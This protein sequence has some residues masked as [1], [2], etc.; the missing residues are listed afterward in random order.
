MA[1][2][3]ALVA[4]SLFG[5][6]L[7]IDHQGGLGL[8]SWVGILNFVFLEFYCLVI[9]GVRFNVAFVSGV[10]IL[11]A[12]E[13]AMYSEL[14]ADRPT[15]FYLTYQAATTFVLPTGIGWWREYV[16]RKDYSTR[17]TLQTARDFLS[18][19]NVLLEA[20][21]RRRTHELL[22]SRDA[23][24]AYDR[25]PGGDLATMK[26]ATISGER[27]ITSAFWPDNC[28]ITQVSPSI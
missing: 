8:K 23:A 15:F 28:K 7:A 18:H 13:A 1:G 11:M 22:A 3:I 19:Q 6:L 2:F 16:L 4:L 26:P 17:A 5:V 12:F 24:I 21:V 9:L 20:E 27:S 25:C 10:V 14:A